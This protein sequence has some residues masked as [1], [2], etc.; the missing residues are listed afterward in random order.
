M[1]LLKGESVDGE[2]FVAAVTEDAKDD[3][4]LTKNNNNGLSATFTCTYTH[5]GESVRQWDGRTDKEKE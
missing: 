5:T 3:R 1:S 2:D 4:K